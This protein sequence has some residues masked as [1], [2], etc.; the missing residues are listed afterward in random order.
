MDAQVQAEAR[1]GLAQVSLSREEWAEARQ[2]TETIQSRRY[3]PVLTQ[4][5][6]ALGTAYLREGD[7]VNA[8]RAFSD[9]VSTADNLL[10]GTSGIAHVLY[11]KGVASAGQAVA[12][13]SGAALAARHTFEQALTTAPAPGFRAR[14]LRQLDILRPADTDGILAG[15]E[16][17]LA[18]RPGDEA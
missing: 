14:I 12:G 15:I 1:F 4:V 7:R 6:V 11:A 16:L 18:G 8:G 3:Q 9:A 5:L 17:V 13:Q 2:I 10:A